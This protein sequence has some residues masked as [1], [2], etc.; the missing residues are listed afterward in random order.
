MAKDR[1]ARRGVADPTDRSMT[2]KQSSKRRAHNPDGTF[3]ADDPSTPDINEA[4]EPVG[5][6]DSMPIPHSVLP[7]VDD[8]PVDSYCAT[9]STP[10]FVPEGVTPEDKNLPDYK[11]ALAS[12]ADRYLAKSSKPQTQPAPDQPQSGSQI[13]DKSSEAPPVSPSPKPQAG[14]A[15]RLDS[16]QWVTP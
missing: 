13:P 10:P 12:V 3:K 7:G 11:D 2:E 4:W 14:R 6:A 5:S 15:R 1:S 16:G 8:D 9:R